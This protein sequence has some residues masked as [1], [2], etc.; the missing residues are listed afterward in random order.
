M[1]LGDLE[2]SV[3]QS[4]L[5]WRPGPFHRALVHLPVRFTPVAGESDRSAPQV[6]AHH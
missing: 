5:L 1:R 2:L 6:A 3:P 4:E